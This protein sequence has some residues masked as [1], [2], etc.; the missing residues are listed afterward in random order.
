MQMLLLISIRG[1]VV[2]PGECF[3]CQCL[4]HGILPVHFH[5]LKQPTFQHNID[6]GLRVESKTNLFMT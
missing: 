3:I 2:H 6:L 5:S 1:L 4:N